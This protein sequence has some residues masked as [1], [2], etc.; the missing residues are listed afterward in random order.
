MAWFNVRDALSHA[1][2]VDDALEV[3]LYDAHDDLQCELV[4]SALLSAGKLAQGAKP[5]ARWSSEAF[6]QV[7]DRLVE[8]SP[9]LN[10]FQLCKVVHGLEKLA[11][12][13]NAT[14]IPTRVITAI[15]HRGLALEGELDAYAMSSIIW[16]MGRFGTGT[17]AAE[18]VGKI[19]LAV[20][21]TTMNAQDLANTLHGLGRLVGTAGAAQLNVGKVVPALAKVASKVSGTAKAQEAVTALSGLAK[22][23]HVSGAEKG[24]RALQQ[25]LG[26]LL[27]GENA[28]TVSAQHLSTMCWA[29]CEMKVF[30]ICYRNSYAIITNMLV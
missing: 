14:A 5:R 23:G 20:A 26:L 8:V 4:A 19:G 22:L 9:W 24:I 12:F 17:E 15:C 28:A 21:A 25:Q 30:L 6:N 18:L 10:V 11:E 1:W 7:A 29:L 2:T 13:S 27:K 16:A 3:A